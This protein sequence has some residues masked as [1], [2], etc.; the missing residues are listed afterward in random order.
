MVVL[1]PLSKALADGDPVYAVIRGGAVNNDGR[2]NGMMAPS[3]EAQE[4]LLREAYRRADVAP[5]QVQYVEAHGTGTLLGDPIEMKALGTVLDTQR[6]AGSKCAVGSVKSNIGHLESAAGIASLIKVAL[7]LKHREIPSTL[8]VRELNPH[9]PFDRLP[10]HVQRELTP[11]PKTEHKALAGVSSFGFGGTNAHLVLEEAVQ[12]NKTD[13]PK[14]TRS[15]D[16]EELLVI[17]A[18]S[19]EAL[20]DFARSYREFLDDESESLRDI[21]YTAGVRRSHHDYR[22]ALVGHSRKAMINGLNDFLDEKPSQG[23]SAA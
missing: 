22:L 23:V 5:G 17:S 10:L 14:D 7:M 8:H 3:G 6:E 11:W 9:I 16:A 1:K 21:C 12:Q 18:R 13:E 4:A 15:D 20:R 2:S 19:R